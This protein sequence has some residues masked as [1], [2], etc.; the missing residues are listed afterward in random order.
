MFIEPWVIDLIPLIERNFLEHMLE[1]KYEDNTI[2]VF[3]R[4]EDKSEPKIMKKKK[5]FRCL[6]ICADLALM[7]HLYNFAYEVYH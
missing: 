5:R 3:N 4:S 6:K 2:I 1:C 7:L